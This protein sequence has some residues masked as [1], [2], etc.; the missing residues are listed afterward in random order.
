MP[1]TVLEEQLKRN[2]RDKQILKIHVLT[3][4]TKKKNK[5]EQEERKV[6][7]FI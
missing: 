1:G 5:V 3:G 2:K 6:N 7:S 4:D